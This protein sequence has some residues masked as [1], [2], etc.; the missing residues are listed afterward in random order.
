MLTPEL[1]RY[2]TLKKEPVVFF[3]SMVAPP[4]EVY[5][6]IEKLG[7]SFFSELPDVT[8]RS[9]YGVTGDSVFYRTAGEKITREAI[10]PSRLWVKNQDLSQCGRTIFTEDLPKEVVT[11][12]F[13]RVQP[14]TLPNYPGYAE[15][16]FTE[17]C[18]LPR[19]EKT[20][21]DGLYLGALIS[22][23]GSEYLDIKPAD[24]VVLY[25]TETVVNDFNWYP[26]ALEKGIRTLVIYS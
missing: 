23:F 6:V 9:V 8:Y 14:V 18:E 2:L 19:D 25:L 16:R 17:Y 1:Y 21:T 12:L 24:L 10:A 26:L 7:K 4:T 5:D 3:N 13:S 15:K 11:E 20:D 22:V